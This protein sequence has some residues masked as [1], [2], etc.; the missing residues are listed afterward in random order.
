MRQCENV[1]CSV[2]HTDEY[3]LN[4]QLVS[5][6]LTSLLSFDDLYGHSFIGLLLVC[7][8]LTAGMVLFL[9]S[10][11][12]FSEKALK[13]HCSLPAQHQ[14]KTGKTSNQLVNKVEH[15]VAWEPEVS[16]GENRAEIKWM[17]ALHSFTSQKHES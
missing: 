14:Q 2:K 12:V 9:L 6:T 5:A 4:L 17:L 8:T 16:K 15:L 13:T 7:F 1:A 10:T 11:A 3:H